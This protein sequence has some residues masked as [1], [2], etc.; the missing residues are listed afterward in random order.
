MTAT[1]TYYK[2]SDNIIRTHKV[3]TMVCV[4]LEYLAY[5]L[6]YATN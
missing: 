3:Y 6:Q 4:L 1:A 5:T 2:D